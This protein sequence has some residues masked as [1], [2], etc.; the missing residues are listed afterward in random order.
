LLP[1][2]STEARKGRGAFFTPPSI[3]QHLASWAID[4]RSEALVLDPT[5]GEA[6]FLDA[7]AKTLIALGLPA[8]KLGQQLFG[9]DLHDA[10]VVEAAE[11]LA[12]RGVRAN[13]ITSDFF[14]VPSPGGSLDTP[15]PLVDA[16]VG[17]PPFVRFQEHTGATRSLSVGAALSQGVRLSGLAS[18]WAASVI[19]AASFLKPDGRI[20]MVLPAEV[21][22]VGYAEPVREWLRNRFERVSLVLFEKLQFQDALADVVLLLAEGQGGC[23]SFSLY[24]V[25]S[26]AELE[27]HIKPY[28]HT[29]VTPPESGKWTDLLIPKKSRVLYRNVLANSFVTLR[30]YGRLELGAVS[31]ANTFFAITEATR[32][33]FGL[34]MDQVEPISPPG[35]KHFKSSSF[36]EDDWETLRD[37]NERVWLFRPSGDDDSE[38]RLLY[39]QYGESLSAHESYKSRKRT[40]WWRPPIV[41]PP[42]LF[43]TYMSHNYPRLINNEAG[44]SFLNSM[45]GVHLRRE[46]IRGF[47]RRCLFLLLIL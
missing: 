12:R 7:A 14:A 20:A 22:T 6:V 34:R 25:A 16:V 32:T 18:S 5:C 8:E 29:N 27:T 9:V 40:P 39:T 21:L 4:G 13:L 15:I 38:S 11:V 1:G 36:S 47:E 26:A 23:D 19:H 30:D 37:A 44:V 46:V 28:N 41:A 45:H 43:F 2:D 24:H 33:K 42:E 35:T 10:S 17:N 31:G 3:A